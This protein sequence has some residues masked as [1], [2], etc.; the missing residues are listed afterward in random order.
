M[1]ASATPG[2]LAAL[3]WAASGAALLRQSMC[4]ELLRP[5]LPR[6]L[7]HV[8]T[9]TPYRR[10]KVS[11]QEGKLR[12][13]IADKNTFQMEKAGLERELKAARAQAEKLTKNMDKVCWCVCMC[14]GGGAAGV[15]R[16]S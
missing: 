10:Q 5:P 11:E 2:A 7:E 12:S 4:D 13:A 1:L 8:S 16:Q 14:V 6:N 15:D 9:P 3:L